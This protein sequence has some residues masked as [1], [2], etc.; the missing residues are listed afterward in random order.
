MIGIEC[1]ALLRSANNKDRQRQPVADP[2]K[3]PI[4]QSFE[5]F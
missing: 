5:G 3:S 1:S 4:C 2:L